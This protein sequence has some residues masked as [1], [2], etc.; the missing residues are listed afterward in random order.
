MLDSKLE[1][2]IVL[3]ESCIFTFNRFYEVINN[4]LTQEVVTTESA[5]KLQQLRQELPRQAETFYTAVGM[6]P[7]QGDLEKILAFASDLPTVIKLPEFQL[8]NL[9]TLWH[10]QFMDLHYFR[11]KLKYRQELLQRLNPVKLKIRRILL[12]PFTLIVSL[13]IFVYFVLLLIF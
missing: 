7:P 2:E 13:G 11:G 1:Q 6:K 3:A 5:E 4:A 8:Q 10:Q 12:N 9:L